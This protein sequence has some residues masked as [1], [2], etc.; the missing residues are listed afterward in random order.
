MLATLRSVAV[1][2]TLVATTAASAVPALAAGYV[3][4]IPA[5]AE[6]DLRPPITAAEA[7][8]APTSPSATITT[9]PVAATADEQVAEAA[10]APAARHS[11]F[12]RVGGLELVTP[13]PDPLLIGFRVP[14]DNAYGWQGH[15]AGLHGYQGQRLGQ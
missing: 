3:P 6:A 10:P 11:V 14:P 5:E 15:L 2:T 12:T 1:L 8:S 4:G 9:A 13:T 7:V